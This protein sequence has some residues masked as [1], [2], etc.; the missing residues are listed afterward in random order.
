[1]LCLDYHQGQQYDA[2]DDGGIRQP[3]A[4]CIAYEDC[5]FDTEPSPYLGYNDIAPNTGSW[6]LPAMQVDSRFY[7]PEH[8]TPSIGRRTPG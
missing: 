3:Y 5:P 4:D 2:E 8:R 6:D 7:V 1:M